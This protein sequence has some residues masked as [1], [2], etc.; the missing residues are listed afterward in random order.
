MNNTR[1]AI[2]A[3]PEV[4]SMF[5]GEAIDEIAEHSQIAMSPINLCFDSMLLF[6]RLNIN[7]EVICLAFP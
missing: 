7:D 1:V 3:A 6:Q 2:T 4:T 5:S